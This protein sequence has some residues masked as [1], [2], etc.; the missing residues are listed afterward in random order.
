M[1]ESIMQ[2]TTSLARG[3]ILAGLIAG[4]L[5]ARPAVAAETFKEQFDHTYPLS[6]G[7]SFTLKDVNGAVSVTAWDRNEVHVVAEKRV[8][9]GSAEEGRRR[10]AALRIDATAQPGAV[11]VDTRF[12]HQSGL[13]GWLSG[14]GGASVNYRIEVPRSVRVDVE[15]VNGAVA[16]AGTAGDLK[17]ETTNGA[18]DVKEV[19]GK[20]HLESTNG[21]ISAVGAA[22]SV[23]ADTTNGG[24]DVELTDVRRADAMRFST[25]NGSVTLKV[26]H[27]IQ[28]SI[29]ANT[30]NGRVETDLPVALRGKASK[31]RLDGD[32]NGGG[33]RLELSTT[34]G[35]IHIVGQR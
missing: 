8:K 24:I 13:F 21:A 10:L 4:S 22:G 23:Q 16:V 28:A 2:K 33:G 30:T 26:P 7:G 27:G 3:L 15:T 12:P 31:R 14:E 17:A 19:R 35:G 11:R 29:V 25:T 20:I 5:A 6:S 32:V 1:E 9:A 18:V 34:N